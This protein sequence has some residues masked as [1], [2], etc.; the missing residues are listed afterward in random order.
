MLLHESNCLPPKYSRVIIEKERRYYQIVN[1]IL[2]G[3][4]KKPVS[5]ER[6]KAITFMLFGMCN[7]IYS[8]YDPKGAVNAEELSEMICAIFLRGIEDFK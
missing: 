7:W 4:L 3:L 5:K 8:W 6:V 1:D 2:Y